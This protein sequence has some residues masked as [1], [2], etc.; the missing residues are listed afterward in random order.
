MGNLNRDLH[1]WAAGVWDF[2]N[3]IPSIVCP[4]SGKISPSYNCNDRVLDPQIGLLVSH[5]PLKGESDRRWRWL[6]SQRYLGQV[7][8]RAVSRSKNERD[9][10]DNEQDEPG[11]NDHLHPA[12]IPL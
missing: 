5:T 10:Y 9:Q 3:E 4:L 1:P 11:A 7:A 12:R 8:A 2:Q 6:V